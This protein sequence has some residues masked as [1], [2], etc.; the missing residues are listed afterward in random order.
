MSGPCRNAR[1]LGVR[2]EA[3]LCCVRDAAM[4]AASARPWHPT[5]AGREGRDGR[6]PPMTPPRS[7]S[8]RGL[9]RTTM[10]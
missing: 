2:C 4:N 1:V 9:P 7:A 6:T 10:V 5:R 3:R 8:E